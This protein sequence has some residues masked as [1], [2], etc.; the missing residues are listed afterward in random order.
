MGTGT[1][2]GAA[3]GKKDVDQRVKDLEERLDNLLTGKVNLQVVEVSDL[4]VSPK[5][6]LR[7]AC[8]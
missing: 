4:Q 1:G 8:E 6:K 7:V 2:G 3:H 5:S